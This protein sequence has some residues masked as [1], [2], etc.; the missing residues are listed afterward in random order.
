MAFDLEWLEQR[1]ED[2][3]NHFFNGVVVG[4]RRKCN[5]KFISAQTCHY[6]A[7][8]KAGFYT[9]RYGFEK[10]VSDVMTEGIIDMLE[11]I[12]IDHEY[13][14]SIMISTSQRNCLG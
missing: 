4:Y 9:S 12:Q 14:N 5:Y 2:L 7:F 3:P 8:A 1:C 13:S 10:A 11:V 6:V